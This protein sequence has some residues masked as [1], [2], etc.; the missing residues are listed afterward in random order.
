MGNLLNG[1]LDSSFMPHGHCFFWTPDI[2]WTHLVSDIVVALAYYLI[3][4]FLIYFVRKRPGLPFP[5]VF[6]LFGLFI[7]ACGTTHLMGAI[8]LWHPYYRLEGMVKAVTAVASIGTAIA[9]YPL[10]PRA[11]KLRS[12]LELERL[13][14][15]L[16]SRNRELAEK[17]RELEATQEQ[18]FFFTA[19]A[20]PHLVW[21]AAPGGSW[22]YFNRLWYEYTGLPHE[23]GGDRWQ[24]AMHPDD[25][26]VFR[27]K[28]EKALRGGAG[29][30]MECRL[31]RAADGAY[32]WHLVKVLPVAD[33]QGRV[34]KWF[35]TCTDMEDMKRAQ[36]EL[37]KSRDQLAVILHSITDSVQV[38]GSDLKLV[39][40]NEAAAAQAGFA[41][42]EEML[43]LSLADIRSR[44]RM[45]DEQGRRIEFEN[46]PT[47]RALS[48]E[49]APKLLVKHCLEGKEDRWLMIGSSPVQA[50]DGSV[51]L[52]VSVSHD[53]TELKNAEEALKRSQDQLR[54]AQKMEAI[55][56][57]AGGVAHDF[58]NLLTAINGYAA[59]ALDEIA[60]DHPLREPLD[61]IHKAGEKA[62]ALTHQMLVFSRKQV[63]A[64]RVF[65][66]NQVAKEMQKLLQRL[67]GGDIETKVVAAP[68]PA[69]IKAD[70]GQVE[71]IIMNLAVNARDA[72]P[73][74]GVFALETSLVDVGGD[75]IGMKPGVKP[76]RYVLLTV[77]DN[78][79]GMDAEVRSH[80]FEPYYTTKERGKGTGFG[81]SIVFGIVDQ[82]GGYIDVYSEPGLGATFKIYLPRVEAVAE[83]AGDGPS[84][85][86]AREL[87][88]S[89]TILVVEDDDSVRRLVIE[90]L[91]KAGYRILE[92]REGDKALEI[93]EAEGAGVDLLLTDVVMARMGGGQLATRVSKE[94]PGIKVIY[95]SGYTGDSLRAQGV[96]ATPAAFLQK[97]FSPIGLLSKVRETLGAAKQG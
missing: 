95:M 38:F 94:R 26:P 91:R 30:E 66:L 45:F 87:K 59:Y 73:Q 1:L 33:K 64:A 55:G 5:W 56:R 13:N 49:S 9:L 2:L 61:E 44:V 42:V 62:A 58:N 39:Y 23:G 84:S 92:A 21:T 16:E 85:M 93:I 67:L 79:M 70:P 78:G 7:L 18:N 37:Q 10:V 83:E 65:D 3:P 24:G 68:E 35:G 90:V 82:A 50:P 51:L 54:Q 11:L 80:I 47:L 28:W 88:G 36:A 97:P 86:E 57:L 41:R 27:E 96:G 48:G 6:R 69:L 17:T 71:Q 60:S 53:I 46:F 32:R 75:A 4:A 81:L 25:H 19:E 31:R 52:A 43:G 76:G 12:P 29:F 8:T 20:I 63:V 22:D 14:L 77:G 34:V 74:G 40:A 89:E 72:M 15:E